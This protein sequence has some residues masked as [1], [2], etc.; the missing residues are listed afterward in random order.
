[1][2]NG[3]MD[4][5][6]NNHGF[7]HTLPSGRYTCHSVSP[8]TSAW[9]EHQEKKIDKRVHVAT[10]VEASPCLLLHTKNKK[11]RNY[12]LL[13]HTKNKKAR[14]NMRATLTLALKFEH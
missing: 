7:V 1:M 9:Q 6:I 8:R 10:F 14:I 11:A 2:N 4:L 12:F 3:D 5:G 13:L